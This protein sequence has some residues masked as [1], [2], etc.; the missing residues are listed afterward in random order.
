M[1]R[2]FHSISRSRTVASR[3]NDTDPDG[4]TKII[5]KLGIKLP[6]RQ[7]VDI[8]QVKVEDGAE[9]NILPLCSF[10]SMFPHALD[11]DGYLLDGF[12]RGSRTTLEY[13]N[14]GKLVNHGSIML[15]LQHYT[16]NSFQDDQF[17]VVETPT[18][19]EIIVGH[20]ASVRLGLIKVMCK[21]LQNPLQLQKQNPTFS[22]KLHILMGEF[23]I[24]G[25]E[26][27]LSMSAVQV[28]RKDTN[29]TPFKTLIQ[30]LRI[31]MSKENAK[32]VPF[33]TPFQDHYVC[34][35]RKA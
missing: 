26:A 11:G 5:T 34:I 20:P 28:D 29:L 32:R 31:K 14:D 17:Y 9:A 6:H 4:K 35:M 18:C 15:K 24:D 10:R 23:L 30:D 13:Y 25:Q 33:K 1:V 27:D 12:L 2:M 19:K 22:L 21:I 7:V 16:N 3:S 8:L